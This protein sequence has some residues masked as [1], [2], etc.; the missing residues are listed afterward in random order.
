MYL[1]SHDHTEKKSNEASETKSVT[2]R[3]SESSYEHVAPST[4]TKVTTA[5][6]AVAPVAPT[7]SLD[8]S[9]LQ[10]QLETLEMGVSVLHKKFG[11]GTIER[12]NKS[13]KFVYVKFSEGEKK[14][15]FPDAFV[16][17]YLILP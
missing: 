8:L 13:E 9:E 15:I 6:V 16:S 17:G 3:K 7:P 14:F 11:I 5:P 4:A 10:Q 1:S 2:A 12:L